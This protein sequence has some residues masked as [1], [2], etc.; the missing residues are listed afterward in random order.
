MDLGEVSQLE[1]SPR[2]AYGSQ[3]NGKNIPPDSTIL[4]TVELKDIAKEKDLEE[5]LIDDRLK[6]G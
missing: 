4:Y 3:G 1:I 2:F 5:V 6:I